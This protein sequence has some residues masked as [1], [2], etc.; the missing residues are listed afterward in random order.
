MA[1]YVMER[2]VSAPYA[3]SPAIRIH[4]PTSIQTTVGGSLS[5]MQSSPVARTAVLE[6][7]P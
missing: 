6:A 1:A 7:W 2:P 5:S 4:V 3:M